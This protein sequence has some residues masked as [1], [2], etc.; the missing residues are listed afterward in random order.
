MGCRN[1]A[2]AAAGGCHT[3]ECTGIVNEGGRAIVYVV[4]YAKPSER[5]QIPAGKLCVLVAAHKAGT[6]AASALYL[7]SP[8]QCLLAKR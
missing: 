7:L 3:D 4:L 2:A 1:W 5:N 8:P 6:L